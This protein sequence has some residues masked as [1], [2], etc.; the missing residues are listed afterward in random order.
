MMLEQMQIK[1]MQIKQMLEQIW[2]NTGAWGFFQ[3][4]GDHFPTAESPQH[5]YSPALVGS[6][7][8]PHQLSGAFIR[9]LNVEASHLGLVAQ[10]LPSSE[11]EL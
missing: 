7:R 4:E 3:E 11:D 6:W 1:Q 8:K 10:M 2:L 5:L 9:R